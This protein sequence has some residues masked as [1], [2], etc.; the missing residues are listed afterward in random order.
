VWFRNITPGT[1]MTYENGYMNKASNTDVK[2]P[3]PGSI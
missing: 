3:N 1:N 2:R